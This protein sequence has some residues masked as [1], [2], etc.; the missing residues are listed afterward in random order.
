MNK[1]LQKIPP[2]HRKQVKDRLKE[3]AEKIQLRRKSLNITQEKLAEKLSISHNT[4]QYIEQGRRIPSLETLFYI[5]SY[6]Q[7]DIT[8]H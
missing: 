4:M 6:L 7:I 1:R 3:V 5:C 2:K 8:I